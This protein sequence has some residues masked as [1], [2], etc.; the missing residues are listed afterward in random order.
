MESI[1]RSWVW[2]NNEPSAIF[3]F[4]T[5]IVAFALLTAFAAAVRLR[6]TPEGKRVAPAH[7]R[8]R[9]SPGYPLAALEA[10]E[11]QDA[12]SRQSG[13]RRR[14][15]KRRVSLL[16]RRLR[17]NR[18]IRDNLLFLSR[19]ASAPMKVG[20]VTPSSQRL[21]RAMAAQLPEQYEICVELGGGT[22]SLTRA[23]L[24]AGMPRDKLI[25]I[26]RDSHLATH[27]R[28][29]FPGVRVLQGDAQALTDLLR[30]EGI[31]KVDAVLSSLPLR[32][33]PRRVRMAVVAESFAALAEG[34]IY[35][36]YTYGLTPPVPEEIVR[37]LSLGGK[38]QTRVWRN[39]PP[40]AVW[41]Y[42]RT[43]E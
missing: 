16:G 32:S 12:S 26:E 39:I 7:P 14:R 27:L 11:P 37:S 29:R 22:G 35:V 38:P 34:G 24:A 18:T 21:G 33:L 8:N 43:G 1:H 36:Q 2:L 30:A 13:G 20:S 9:P 41:R 10:A 28:K 40:A 42:S 25:V 3:I 23:L 4:A 15:A 5:V 17:R 31:E 6:R 19:F